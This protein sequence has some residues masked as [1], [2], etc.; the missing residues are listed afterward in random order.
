MTTKLGID[1][2]VVGA[3]LAGSVV[4]RQL[5]DAGN[6][7]LVVEKRS[8]PAGNCLD[9]V[10]QFGILVQ[11][12]GPH[13]FHTSSRKIA[14]YVKR[15]AQW[16]EYDLH[17]GSMIDG[18]CIE[19]PF[20]FKTLHQFYSSD[21]A[22][23]IQKTLCEV[24]PGKETVSITEL[25]SCSSNDIREL[26]NLLFEKEYKPYSAKQWGMP[27][28]DVDP[29]ILKRVPFYLNDLPKYL[30]D[31]Y[32]WMPHTSFLHFFEN[33]LSHPNITLRFNE[34][35]MPSIQFSGDKVLYDGA[36]LR[37]IVFTGMV[38]ELFSFRHGELPYRSLSFQFEHFNK[39][40]Y[41]KYPIVALPSDEKYTRI[42]EYSKLPV[43]SHAL[44]TTICLESSEQYVKGKN[45]PYYPIASEQSR[46]T[47]QKYVDYSKN[48]TNLH[49]CGRLAQ[50][51]YMNMD[52]VIESALTLSESL[53]H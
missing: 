5:A 4:A 27:A 34:D 39:P 12:F 19:M 20:S 2:L 47:Y 23:L 40:E 42:T 24:F 15:F 31:Q 29:T 10:D 7:V 6:R 8:L 11:D 22:S 38:D 43:Q 36:L 37:G 50:F 44:G 32:V 48:F 49:L 52:Q 46:E 14:D 41:Q 9:H 30:N 13:T 35:A 45:L 1:Y 53:L 21:E 28:A 16:D 25:L 26:G 18:K 33:I 3:G 51:K 17:Y